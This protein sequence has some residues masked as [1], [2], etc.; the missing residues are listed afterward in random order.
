MDVALIDVVVN[1]SAPATIMHTG[2]YIRPT[3]EMNIEPFY[4]LSE[5]IFE[6]ISGGVAQSIEPAAGSNGQVYEM[7]FAVVWRVSI[8]DGLINFDLQP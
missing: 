4:G 2:P 7:I 1:F 6:R 8:V 3:L 5:Y